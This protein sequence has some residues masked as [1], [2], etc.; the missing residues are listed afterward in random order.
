MPENVFNGVR[1]KTSKGWFRK[2]VVV[3]PRQVL[4]NGV[5]VPRLEVRIDRV[6]PIFNGNTSIQVLTAF[7]TSRTVSASGALTD[8]ARFLIT[9]MI[10]GWMVP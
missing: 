9:L 4:A 3:I 8:T 5:R 7:L 2:Q 1:V 6:S 10:A